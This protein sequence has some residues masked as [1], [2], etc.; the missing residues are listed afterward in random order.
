M[1]V[2]LCGAAGR[3]GRLMARELASSPHR[4][5]A[6][7]DIRQTGSDVPCYASLKDVKE[8]ADV[9]VDFSRPACLDDLLEF[10]LARKLPLVIAT[11]GHSAAQKK[12]IE[13]AANSVPIFFSSN[14]SFGVAIF[15][16]LVG[17]VAKAFPYAEVEIVE[18]HH[19]AKS[20]VPSG[21][22]LA[23][24]E[25]VVSARGGYVTVG[26]REGVRNREEVAISSLRLGGTV[27]THTVIFD[28]GYQRITLTHSAS[29]R[30]LYTRGAINAISFVAD[31]PNGLYSVLD[32]AAD[33]SPF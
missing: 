12:R 21:T 13:E 3:M 24:A 26:R 29:S 18:A 32:L 5:V 14:M 1:R 31:K 27:G 25:R 11:T 33:K 16:S 9:V 22:A 23:I 7:V 4:L 19:S 6:A 17:Q 10:A 2:I 20:D 15:C 30:T 8:E 28:T